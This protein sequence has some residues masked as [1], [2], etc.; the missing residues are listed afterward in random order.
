MD[1]IVASINYID[2]LIDE[3]RGSEI[4]DFYKKQFIA[5]LENIR[6]KLTQAIDDTI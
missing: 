2:F 4:G 5:H 3:I 6:D 1:E